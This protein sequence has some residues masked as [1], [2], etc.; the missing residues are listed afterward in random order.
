[1]SA[2][3]TPTSAATSAL[4]DL[5]T[6]A[7]RL[8]ALGVLEMAGL[9][10][11]QLLS[12]SDAAAAPSRGTG[13]GLGSGSGSGSSSGSG[14]PRGSL[15]VLHPDLVPASALAT[16]MR[17]PSAPDQ[18]GFVVED[19]TDLDQFAPLDVVDQP[20][21][22]AYLLTGLDRGDALSNWTPDEAMPHLLGQGRTPMTVTEGLHWVLQQPEVLQRNHCFMTTAS[23]VRRADGRLDARTPALWIS[24]GTGRDGRA[25]R[26]APKVGWC[27]AGNRHTWL[28]IAS[29]ASREPLPTTH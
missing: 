16:L 6:Q 1:M 25:R 18:E 21:P 11:E 13:T 27:W 5:R 14:S 19:M 23:R 17:L 20:G 10:V 7:E 29:A 12:G 2:V 3:S 24:N 22:P 4:P 8:S 15:L 9:T 28:G 26:D